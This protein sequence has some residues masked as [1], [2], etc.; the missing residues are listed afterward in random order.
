MLLA[1]F[2]LS[3][4]FHF[5][6]LAVHVALTTCACKTGGMKKKKN[7]E[8]LYLLLHVVESQH[9]IVFHFVHMPWAN[10]KKKRNLILI[11]EKY[12]ILLRLRKL[13]PS[14][15]ACRLHHRKHLYLQCKN[16]SIPF[17]TSSPF[18]SIAKVFAKISTA[19]KEYTSHKNTLSIFSSSLTSVLSSF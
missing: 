11:H 10:E 9:A 15:E 2:I 1:P 19:K 17:I 16:C 7:V 13:I 14:I 3:F 4:I 8:K 5:V 6:L 12:T 18:I